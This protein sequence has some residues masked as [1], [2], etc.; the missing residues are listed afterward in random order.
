MT[1]NWLLYVARRVAALA[2]LGAVGGAIYAAG[3]IAWERTR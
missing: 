2:L 3:W 1:R